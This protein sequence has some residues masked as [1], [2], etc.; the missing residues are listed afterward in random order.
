[1]ARVACK[2]TAEVSCLVAN[3]LAEL[4]QPCELCRKEDC[5]VLTG[6][7]PTGGRVTIRLLPELVLD[8]EGGDALLA[9]IRERRC[10]HGP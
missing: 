2:D 8:V 5:V 7:S 4:E 9:Q 10:P 6:A 3:L 1:M